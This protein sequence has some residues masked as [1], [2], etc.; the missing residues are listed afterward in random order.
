[1]VESSKKY[2]TTAADL[3]KGMLTGLGCCWDQQSSPSKASV[4]ELMMR[5]RQRK[6]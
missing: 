6:V 4:V 1:M 5:F 2:A 3:M